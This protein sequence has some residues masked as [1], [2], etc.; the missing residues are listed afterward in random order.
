M[1]PLKF[2]VGSV[3]PE[4]FRV[5]SDFSCAL[6]YNKTVQNI[7]ICTGDDGVVLVDEDGQYRIDVSLPSGNCT[8]A[9]AVVD[10]SGQVLSGV[11]T[12]T[13]RVSDE[14]G[15]C[16][17][18]SGVTC[19]HGECS[20]AGSDAHCVCDPG[21][22]GAY[23]SETMSRRRSAAAGGS[24][25]GDRRDDGQDALAVSY[26]EL[27]KAALVDRLYEKDRAGETRV[28]ARSMVGRSGLDA[29]QAL[30]E[31]V[32]RDG[33]AGDLMETGVWQAPRAYAGDGRTARGQRVMPAQLG[34][35]RCA[36]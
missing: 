28:V 14:Q 35:R 29:L 17:A 6:R 18:E 36:R 1:V 7:S 34:S 20:G 25:G 15:E 33:V 11:A 3:V 21:Y 4:D 8:L 5:C 32:L 30:V 23:C 2:S 13:F 24:Y 26:V 10:R 27:V 19:L 22:S 31:A 16:P 12:R 9:S